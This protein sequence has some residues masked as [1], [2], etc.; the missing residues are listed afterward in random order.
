MHSH[1]YNYLIECINIKDNEEI[2]AI[3]LEYKRK[4]LWLVIWVKSKTGFIV[5]AELSGWTGLYVMLRCLHHTL[6][7]SKDICWVL[8]TS[9]SYKRT[10][11]EN[12]W[13]DPESSFI[14]VVSVYPPEVLVVKQYTIPLAARIKIFFKLDITFTTTCFWSD[15]QMPNKE[16]V[17]NHLYH[18]SCPKLGVIIKVRIRR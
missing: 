4:L 17:R 11:H 1:L 16:K 13:D 9:L 10:K 7:I 6:D 18:L 3:Q 15:S 12:V 2:T 14:T 5:H 8:Q